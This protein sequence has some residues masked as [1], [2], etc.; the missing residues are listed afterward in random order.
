MLDLWQIKFFDSI[1]FCNWH[2]LN[3]DSCSEHDHFEHLNDKFLREY[4]A[5]NEKD[6]KERKASIEVLGTLIQV[7]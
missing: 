7:L 3:K 4:Q 5:T 2:N 1:K 6:D